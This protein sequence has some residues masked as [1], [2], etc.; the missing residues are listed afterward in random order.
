MGSHATIPA[1][2]FDIQ[3]PFIRLRKKNPRSKP[4]ALQAM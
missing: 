3:I 4:G 2:L 1:L